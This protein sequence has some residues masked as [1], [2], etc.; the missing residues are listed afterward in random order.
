M[1]INLIL[2]KFILSYI[3]EDVGNQTT[4]LIVRDS[5]KAYLKVK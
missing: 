5:M 1:E 4:N 3:Y 2:I